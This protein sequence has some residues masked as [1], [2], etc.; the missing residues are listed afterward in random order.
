M[1]QLKECAVCIAFNKLAI[2]PL[3]SCDFFFFLSSCLSCSL[4]RKKET[5]FCIL[6]LT[7]V[8]SLHQRE[9]L[10]RLTQTFQSI[11]PQPCCPPAYFSQGARNFQRVGVSFVSFSL[12]SFLPSS[13]GIV[14]REVRTD[15][16]YV[17]VLPASLFY[18]FCFPVLY[19]FA[20]ALT[21]GSEP[22]ST[23]SVW[24]NLFWLYL[25]KWQFLSG[26][27]LICRDIRRTANQHAEFN[28]SYT[29]FDTKRCL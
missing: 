17:V 25:W 1:F 27:G 16:E 22:K 9:K 3:Y 11:T 7:K 10:A 14:P 13:P 20:N 15:P 8:G 26:V 12:D 24:V 18:T 6:A 21:T 23:L 5:I 19:L 29:L 28:K 4:V 2:C